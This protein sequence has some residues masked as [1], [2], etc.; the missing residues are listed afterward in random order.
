MRY[1]LIRARVQLTYEG[2][3]GLAAKRFRA[4]LDE[5]P[6]WTPRAT[7]WPWRRSRAAS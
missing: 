1:Q 7:A 3:P 5:D 4:Q 6:K 2:T